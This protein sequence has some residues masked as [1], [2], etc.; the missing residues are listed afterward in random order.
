MTPARRTELSRMVTAG[1]LE[2]VPVDPVVCRTMVEQARR[3]GRTAA[4]GRD[5]GDQEGAFQLAY[6][7]CRKVALALVLAFGVRPSGDRGHHADTF[8]AAAAILRNHS[9]QVGV[10]QSLDD[11]ADLR[12][13][14]SGA[15]YR[16]EVV[17]ADTVDDALA[18]L[19]ELLAGLEP[20]MERRLSAT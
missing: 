20:V 5:L 6:D 16:A 11:A 8:A 14:R 7:G 2:Q 12:F 9:T 3:H 18:I 19:D 4:A 10:R 13:A 15:E 17:S 1:E